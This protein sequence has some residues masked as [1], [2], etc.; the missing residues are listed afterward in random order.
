MDYYTIPVGSIPQGKTGGVP[1]TSVPHYNRIDTPQADAYVSS[2]SQNG[3][4]PEDTSLKAFCMPS[5]QQIVKIIGLVP[6]ILESGKQALVAI[7]DIVDLW[8][9]R[10]HGNDGHEI[11]ACVVPDGLA[12]KFLSPEA[13]A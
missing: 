3:T 9:T 12:A 7:F 4:I 2:D 1:P 6:V 13:E 8:K 11:K 5:P 10:T